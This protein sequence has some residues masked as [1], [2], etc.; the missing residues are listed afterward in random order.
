ML[1]RYQKPEIKNVLLI[2]SAIMQGIIEVSGEEGPNVDP[3]NPIDDPN[4]PSGG[5]SNMNSVWEEE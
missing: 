4:D 3:D 1:K 2:A 5:L